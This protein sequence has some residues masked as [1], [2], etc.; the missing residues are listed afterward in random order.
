MLGAAPAA[1][2][3]VLLPSGGLLISPCLQKPPLLNLAVYPSL[4][5]VSHPGFPQARHLGCRGLLQCLSS[6][7]SV[8]GGDRPVFLVCALQ[9][10]PANTGHAGQATWQALWFKSWL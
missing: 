5:L 2:W 6:L 10:V 7:P 3:Q 9:Q 1:C 8:W 4:L